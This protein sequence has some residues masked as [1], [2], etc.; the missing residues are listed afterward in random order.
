MRYY[1]LHKA[2]PITI[3]MSEMEKLKHREVKYF[4]RSHIIFRKW[5]R[6]DVNPQCLALEPVPLTPPCPHQIVTLNCVLGTLQGF[7]ETQ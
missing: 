5:R 7:S 6:S 2:G 3:P 4:S 1:L